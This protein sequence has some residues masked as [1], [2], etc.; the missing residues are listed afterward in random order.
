VFSSVWAAATLAAAKN[1]PASSSQK[2]DKKEP[3]L[4]WNPPQVDAPVPSLSATP[5]CSLPDVLEQAGQRAEALIEHLRDFDA[6]EQVRYVETD[7]M[8]RS[9]MDLAGKFDYLVDFGEQSEVFNLRETR[10]S[11][12]G[13][14]DELSAKVDKG[15]TALAL[16]FHPDLRTDYEMRCEGFTQW[17]NQPA[18]VVYFRQI[19][20]KR[21]RTLG[22]GTPTKVYHVGLKG[23]A[24]IAADSGQIIHLETNLVEAIAMVSNV[25]GVVILQANAI[26]VDYAPVKFQVRNVEIWLPKYAVAYSD[27]GK[28]RMIIQHTFSDF[29]LFSVQVHQVIQ[30]PK[31]P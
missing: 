24:W 13:S 4:H 28:R 25:N 5:P 7:M 18:W 20:G 29:K 12:T 23:R 11:L 10:T 14:H 26:S 2:K 9:E 3:A 6:Q 31:E 27:F 30:K 16:V 8:G 21:P 19:K 22:I 1:P 15:L 17:N